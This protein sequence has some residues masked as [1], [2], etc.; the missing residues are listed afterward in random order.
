MKC[1]GGA[2]NSSARS[3]VDLFPHD[4]LTPNDDQLRL[5]T[6]EVA[7]VDVDD[8]DDSAVDTNNVTNIVTTRH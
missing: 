5:F 4:P 8:A 3:S 7:D 1:D 6:S 2:S